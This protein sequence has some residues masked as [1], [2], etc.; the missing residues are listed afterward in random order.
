M[1]IKRTAE[2]NRNKILGLCCNNLIG[3]A[4]KIPGGGEGQ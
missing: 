3:S 1:E 2:K 4:I